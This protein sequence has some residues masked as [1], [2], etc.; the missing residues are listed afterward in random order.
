[1]TLINC[2]SQWMLLC[3]I[4]CTCVLQL[5][6]PEWLA[7]FC[8]W[9]QHNGASI[10]SV[11]LVHDLKPPVHFFCLSV[12]IYSVYEISL[13]FVQI[14]QSRNKLDTKYLQSFI[15]QDVKFLASLL[16][17]TSVSALCRLVWTLFTWWC[18]VKIQSL[19]WCA[20]W[21]YTWEF[22]TWLARFALFIKEGE[23]ERGAQSKCRQRS[24]HTQSHM[25]VLSSQR[26][27]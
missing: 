4:L 26:P 16:S 19:H 14:S 2:L 18:T 8:D 10:Q 23:R 9:S 13:C 17:F 21:I 27:C 15:P 24:V 22:I 12:I 11:E 5:F 20:L 7:E 1:M 25:T 6:L 3:F